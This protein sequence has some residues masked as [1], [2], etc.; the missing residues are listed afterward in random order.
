MSS[1][2]TLIGYGSVASRVPRAKL[3]SAF[4][5]VALGFS[6]FLN[7]T[8]EQ[9]ARIDGTPGP[10]SREPIHDLLF[11]QQF[12]REC[13]RKGVGRLQRS[14]QHPALRL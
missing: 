10:V 5:A 3:A 7:F 13:W 12:R 14:E 2:W 6:P 8:S 1:S 4:A 9:T 11:D